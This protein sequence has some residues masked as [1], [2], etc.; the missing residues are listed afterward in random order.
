MMQ[1]P[2]FL[3]KPQQGGGKV[4]RPTDSAVK[5]IPPKDLSWHPNRDPKSAPS[6]PV[7]HF[8]EC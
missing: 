3:F 8:S 5:K 2:S 4:R 7:S 1:L 6:R